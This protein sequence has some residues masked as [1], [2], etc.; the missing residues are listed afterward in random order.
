MRLMGVLGVLGGLLFAWIICA[1][2]IAV[3]ILDPCTA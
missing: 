3:A 1:Q 2:W